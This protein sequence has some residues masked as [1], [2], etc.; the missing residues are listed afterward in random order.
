MI[1][2]RIEPE[3]RLPNSMLRDEG[4][5]R[6]L[7]VA[8]AVLVAFCVL[9]TFV[10]AIAWARGD[11]D[12]APA[13]A[14]GAL[15][16]VNLA[17]SRSP[18]RWRDPMRVE[19][20]RAAFGAVLAP[21]AYLV[22]T[23]PFGHW[24]PGFL[25][26]CLT[27][28]VTVGVLSGSPRASRILVTYYMALFAVSVAIAG[29]VTVA[30][31]IVVGGGMVIA[32]VLVSEV[33]AVLGQKLAVERAQRV[34]IERLML[35]VFPARV[36]SALGRDLVVADEFDS[37]SILFADIEGFTALSDQM[38]ASEVVAMLNEVF[39]QLDGMV[40]E[41]G[42]EKIKTIGDCY[43]VAAGVPEPRVDHAQALCAFGLRMQ[44]FVAE[45]TF[46]GRALRFRVG[47]NSGPVFAG[48]IGRKR[49]LYDLWGDA[50]NV[51]SRMESTGIAGAV[52]ITDATYDL[53]HTGFTCEERG[54]VDVK[55]K[56]QM[57]TWRVV[58]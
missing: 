29:D 34:H 17:A 36:A 12:A 28:S 45:R 21:V 51:A 18:A 30:R 15:L 40:D 5:R 26:M 42:L 52:Q 46:S 1:D 8:D 38:A 50:V 3:E 24:W 13:L 48:V 27:G 14:I 43:M 39:S 33:I 7:F 57:R 22:S 55:G 32:A 2:M 6:L 44:A 53:V 4:P 31:A 35:R 56:G 49:F 23:R 54:V 19:I 11:A 9:S 58:A 16:V 37:A 10:A 41:M 20:I 47:I 25:L